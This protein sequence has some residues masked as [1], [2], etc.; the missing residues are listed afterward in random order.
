M[1]VEQNIIERRQFLHLAAGT[2]LALAAGAADRLAHAATPLNILILGGTRFLGIHLTEAAL[3]RGHGVT[4][5]NRGRTRTELFPNIPRLMGD[6]DGISNGGL[7][8]L[9]GQRFDAVIDT[10][11]YVPRHVRL[12]AERLAKQAPHYLF[13]ST[14]SVYRGFDSAND[15]ESPLGTL[16]DPTVETVDGRTYGPL[17]ALCEQEALK[18]YAEQR[19]TILRP[20]LIVGPYDNTD[21]F[22]YWPARCAR[23]GRFIAPGTPQDPI[24]IIDAR[25]LANYSLDCLEQRITGVFNVISPPGEFLM[26]DLVNQSA[27]LAANIAQPPER[28]VPVWLPA[29]FLSEQKIQPWSDMPVWVPDTPDTFGFSRTSVDR[30]AKTGL[31]IRSLESTLTDTLRWHLDRPQAERDALRSGL[32][33]ERE[34]EVLAA[35]D[36][37]QASQVGS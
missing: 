5:F 13:I 14:V 31:R 16:D 30:A 33:R 36:T 2:G 6:R 35:W 26:G 4:F 29:E 27:Q 11:G 21:R 3:A 28:P 34:R 8:A 22:T 15:E 19:C 37:A 18:A 12:S 23:G 24:Q 1:P 9:E 17:K 10:S 32:K 20:G 25:D 7:Q